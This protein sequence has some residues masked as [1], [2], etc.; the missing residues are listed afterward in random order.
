MNAIGKEI[1]C[2]HTLRLIKKMLTCGNTDA[3]TGT[4]SKSDIGT[5]QGNVASPTIAN[6]VLD[7]LDKFMEGYKLEYEQGELR[8]KKKLYISLNN[9]RNWTKD[10]KEKREL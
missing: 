3:A 1:R 10:P 8:K 2:E 4:V 9:K 6:I 5:P 7:K